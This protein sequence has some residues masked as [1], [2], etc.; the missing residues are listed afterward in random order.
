MIAHTVK[1]RRAHFTGRVYGVISILF[2][3]SNICSGRK[4][5]LFLMA[6]DLRVQIGAYYGRNFASSVHPKMYT[7]NL[8][9]L[10]SKS[11]VLK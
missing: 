2:C 3:F 9:R 8:D 4:N 7:P 1:M 11:L 5:V 6:D 10:A